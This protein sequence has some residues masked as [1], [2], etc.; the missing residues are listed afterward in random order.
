MLPA[1]V[2]MNATK[3]LMNRGIENTAEWI[4]N[5]TDEEC[6]KLVND[7][8]VNSYMIVEDTGSGYQF[9]DNV[10]QA[11]YNRQHG[12]L[13]LVDDFHFQSGGVDHV[14]AALMY[15]LK[16][17]NNLVNKYYIICDEVTDLS[18]SA[19]KARDNVHYL[20][21]VYPQTFIR[22]YGCLC[23]ESVVLSYR[24]ISKWV[25]LQNKNKVVD[26]DTLRQV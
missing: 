1:K 7:G 18:G 17:V 6:L 15:L 20:C 10:V 24:D 21:T 25:V 26:M 13:H 16:D 4:N 14:N 8:F 12:V 22:I 11:K 19:K 23:F 9:W 5:H 3:L 2:Q